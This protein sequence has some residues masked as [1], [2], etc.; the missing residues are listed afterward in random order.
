[1][2]LKYCPLCGRL[3]DLRQI[4]DEGEVPFCGACSRPFFPFSYP[5]VIVAVLNERG[6]IALLRQNKVTANNWVLVAGYI[7]PGETAEDCVS[8]EVLE[9]TGLRVIKCNY[10]SSYGHRNGAHL[11]LAFAAH[12]A[13][14]EF[15]RSQ[16]VDD[17][18]W[19]RLEDAVDKLRPGSI[20]ERV[21]SEVC[22]RYRAERGV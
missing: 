5:C 9:E 7:K 12:V 17:I 21:Y 8:R 15:A 3:L 22:R 1:M 4:G 13:E 11:M 2:D 19:F 20:G 18:A 14:A 6:E 10:L 16:E